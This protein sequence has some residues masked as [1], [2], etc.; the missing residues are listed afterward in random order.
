MIRE[1]R[2]FREQIEQRVGRSIPDAMWAELVKEGFPR[3]RTISDAA[4]FVKEKYR[5]VGL[6]L[7]KSGEEVEFI[8][9]AV[10][11]HEQRDPNRTLRR[12]AVSLLLAEVALAEPS[13][14]YFRRHRLGG[15]L[16]SWDAAAAW[17]DKQAGRDGKPTRWGPITARKS[18]RAPFEIKAIGYAVA[19]SNWAHH[20]LVT[21]GGVL[22]DLRL[23]CESLSR[24]VG[25]QPAEAV[26]FVL[27]NEIPLVSA[28]RVREELKFP[29]Q[30]A[31]RIVLTIAPTLTPQEV[32]EEYKKA[33]QRFLGAGRRQR[34]M[35]EK[36]LRLA[37][38]SALRPKDETLAKKMRAWNRR[39]RRWKYTEVTNFGR[40]VL[41]AR[42]RLLQPF[43]GD[44]VRK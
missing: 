12:E 37:A 3:Q 16:L 7:P 9:S 29:V 15:K 36:H 43:K 22:D 8:R 4:E 28:I 20:K 33:R 19:G 2:H 24:L 40:D 35:K 26:M 10:P 23:R 13:V 25:W 39:Y 41:E 6:P 34:K 1:L 14:E 5:L 31:S 42:G 32:A 38:F 27:T 18:E 17:I 21:H 30:S 44:L 11:H